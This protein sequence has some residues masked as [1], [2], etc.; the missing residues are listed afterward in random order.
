MA[1]ENG[2][3]HLQSFPNPLQSSKGL[4][5]GRHSAADRQPARSLQSV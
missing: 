3:H 2:A 5:R 1:L 4:Q